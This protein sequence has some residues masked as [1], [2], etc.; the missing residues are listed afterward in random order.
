MCIV[1]PVSY[2][3]RKLNVVLRGCDLYVAS[4]ALQP[5]LLPHRT[6]PLLM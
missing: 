1:Q 6:M 3:S 5:L 4:T 2:V